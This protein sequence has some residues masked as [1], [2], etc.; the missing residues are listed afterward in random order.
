[1]AGAY[2][3][4]IEPSADERGFFARSVCREEFARHGLDST[5]IQQSVSSNPL[6]GT[7]R[8]LHYQAPPHEEERLVRVTRGSVFDVIVD[9]RPESPTY[10]SWFAAELSADNRRQ[11]YIPK[12]FAHGF[13]TTQPDTEMLYQ[14][15]V[16]FHPEVSRGIRWDDSNLAIDW[17][18]A[19]NRLVSRKDLQL[20]P[21]SSMSPVP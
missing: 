12:G 19:A 21:F 17:P 20:P 1:L 4:E 10:G 15:T 9:I 11:L 6:V 2:L 16:A 8:G 13:Q 7:L 18:A 14:M 5:F 3:I